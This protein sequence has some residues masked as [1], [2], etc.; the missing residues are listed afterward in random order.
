MNNPNIHQTFPTSPAPSLDLSASGSMDGPERRHGQSMIDRAERVEVT[1]SQ[2][3]MAGNNVNNYSVNIVLNSARQ[4]NSTRRREP[5]PRPKPSTSRTPSDKSSTRTM[6]NNIARDKG[7][8][9]EVSQPAIASTIFNH[10][11]HSEVGVVSDTCSALWIL[12]FTPS[13]GFLGP[14]GH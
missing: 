3:M 6:V 12:V 5:Y 4:W 7:K 10:G 9:C 8:A 11:S 14:S 2:L 1:G 13:L